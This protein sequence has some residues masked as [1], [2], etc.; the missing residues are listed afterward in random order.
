VQADA[1][2]TAARALMTRLREQR[3]Q[4]RQATAGVAD[5]SEQPTVEME[6]VVTEPVATELAELEAA[7][8][9]EAVI[10]QRGRACDPE[11]VDGEVLAD[12]ADAAEAAEAA[13]AAAE[14]PPA[15]AVS[16]DQATV[17]SAAL[18]RED[19]DAA[20]QPTVES[21][22]VQPWSPAPPPLAAT[23]MAAAF[24]HHPA[25]AVEATDASA[26]PP[27]A[28]ALARAAARERASAPEDA[29][30]SA[31][32]QP[33]LAPSPASEPD[34]PVAPLAVPPAAARAPRRL[35]RGGLL[36]G[37]LLAIVRFLLRRR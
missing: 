32:P 30:A 27:L 11:V 22:A 18:S 2:A 20:E 5:R 15:D 8:G 7:A 28:E 9:D 35:A 31:P 6:A 3:Q 14:P 33:N 25:F 21:D 16:D 26:L 24:S 23:D 4:A 12:A 29:G 1:M 13:E 19:I 34:R 37:V 36:L 17:E 10:T